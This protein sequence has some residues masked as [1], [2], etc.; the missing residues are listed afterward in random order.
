LPR[1]SARLMAKNAWAQEQHSTQ[2]R[3]NK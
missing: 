2:P 1:R 3:I